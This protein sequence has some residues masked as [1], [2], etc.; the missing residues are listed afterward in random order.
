[1]TYDEVAAPLS[2]AMGRDGL[3]R[4]VTTVGEAV[5]VAARLG[6]E[7]LTGVIGDNVSQA[8]SEHA[9]AV[10]AL[11]AGRDAE[12]LEHALH[13]ADLLREV[14]PEGVTR[15]LVAR[16]DRELARRA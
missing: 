14:G 13:A 4:S 2:A 11:E 16:A 3:T 1:Q 5:D 15:L 8:R 12:A 9:A 10:S 7:T 6:P